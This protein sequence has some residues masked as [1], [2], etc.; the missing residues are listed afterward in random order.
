MTS[1]QA[2]MRLYIAG[3]SSAQWRMFW[4]PVIGQPGCVPGIKGLICL[5]SEPCSV[6]TDSLLLLETEQQRPWRILVGRL[7]KVSAARV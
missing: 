1:V 5:L 4:T 3:I 7:G 2:N 6:A